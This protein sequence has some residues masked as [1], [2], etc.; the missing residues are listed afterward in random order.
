[1]KSVLAF[2]LME[3]LLMSDTIQAAEYEVI[4]RAN[5]EYVQH[6]GTALAGDL[7]LPKGIDKA[8]V[9]VAV[10][11]GGWQGSSR[12]NYQYWGPYLAKNGYAV[13][14]I[15]YRLA[16]PKAKTFPA[17]VYDVK[18]AVQFV[19]AKA[20]ELGVDPDRI[21]AIGDSA[22]AHL[23]SL[24]ALAGSEPLF[25]AEYRNDPHASVSASVKAVV[26]IYGVY[27][28]Q[29]QWEHDQL[30]RPHDQITE[31]FIG[32]PPTANRRSYFDASPTSYAT[33]DK[34]RTR[35]LLVYGTAD[36]VVDYKT[37]SERFLLSLKQAR[38]FVRSVV[39][40]GGP[41]FWISDPVEEAGSIGSQV[42]PRML[43]FLASSL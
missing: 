10:H 29:A 41:H 32:A 22:G 43:R 7:Y 3:L 8:P 4:T 31:T 15:S 33:S 34:N 26:G 13:F 1:M 42:G 11:G 37:Q 30:T 38:F 19:R 6:D 40:P 28:M 5:I 18:A 39:I 23:A 12:A 2:C 24:T 21:G 17:A 9:L 27:D 36:D 16:K 25:S 14:A 35:F 20:G